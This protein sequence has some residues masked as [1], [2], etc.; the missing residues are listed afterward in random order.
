MDAHD[1]EANALA[2]QAQTEHVSADSEQLLE[3]D[4]A[5]VEATDT[6]SDDIN[7]STE[8]LDTDNKIIQNTS[9]QEANE[10]ESEQAVDSE[11]A[12]PTKEETQAAKSKTTI[13]SYKNM[14]ENVAEQLLPQKSMFN[15][16]TPK[17]PK[18]RSRKPKLDQKKLT[19]V[20]KPESDN[21]DSES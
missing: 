17:V 11:V 18:A 4:R 2:S 19:Q 14:I 20:E 9:A 15:L 7:I 21:T 1:I 12:Q 10:E 13:A 6:S 16:T 5:L 3:A 8:N